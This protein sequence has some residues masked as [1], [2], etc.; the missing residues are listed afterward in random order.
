MN[1]GFNG[2]PVLMHDCDNRSDMRDFF[3]R[4]APPFRLYLQVLVLL[5][6]IFA[7][8]RPGAAAGIEYTEQ[9]PS[10]EDLVMKCEA[11]TIG[12]WALGM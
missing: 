2:R 4:Q 9:F 8:Y 5:D 6:K 12:T 11:D 3:E 1:A 7:M 10:F